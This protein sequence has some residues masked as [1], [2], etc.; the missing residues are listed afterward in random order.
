ME[1]VRVTFWHLQS[2]VIPCCRIGKKSL[3]L[4]WSESFQENKKKNG[5]HIWWRDTFPHNL[6]LIP[7]S[8]GF[9]RKILLTVKE[10]MKEAEEAMALQ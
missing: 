4:K 10:A 5:A 1:E 8:N 9:S 2:H 3:K 7:V 6:G